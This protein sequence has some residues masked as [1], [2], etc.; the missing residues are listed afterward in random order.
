MGGEVLSSVFNVNAYCEASTTNWVKNY[1]T[2]YQIGMFVCTGTNM[3]IPVF[4]KVTDIIKHNEQA[5]I[6]FNNF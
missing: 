3:E 4:R 2:E 6:V 5:F 1:G